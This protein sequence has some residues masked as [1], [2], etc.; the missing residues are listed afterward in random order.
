MAIPTL[1]VVFW[2]NAIRVI[3]NALFSHDLPSVTTL[4]CRQFTIQDL[5]YPRLW[6]LSVLVKEDRVNDRDYF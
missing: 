1:V 2:K 6:P 3:H 4:C 5:E